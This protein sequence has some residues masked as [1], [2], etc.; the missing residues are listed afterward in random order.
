MGKGRRFLRAVAVG[1]YMAVTRA[2]LVVAVL[3]PSVYFVLN[4]SPFPGQLTRFLRTVL[5]GTIEIGTLQIAPV[6]WKV[7]LLD[8]R[9]KED[10]DNSLKAL[11]AI[12]AN[13]GHQR[14]GG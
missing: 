14:G 4:S 11:E 2:I 8:V 13:A 10:K 9:L 1:L 6:P 3:V 7:D 12:L 5:P